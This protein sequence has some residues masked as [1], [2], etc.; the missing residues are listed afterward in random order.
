[1]ASE[2]IGGMALS[3]LQSVLFEARVG[4][5]LRLVGYSNLVAVACVTVKLSTAF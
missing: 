4:L 5:W 1:M 2:L 3:L